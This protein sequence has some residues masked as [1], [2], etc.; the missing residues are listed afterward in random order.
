MTKTLII[1]IIFCLCT[2]GRENLPSSSFNNINK[3]SVSTGTLSALSMFQL[4]WQM[5]VALI[6][7]SCFLILKTPF[8]TAGMTV[9]QKKILFISVCVCVHKAGSHSIHN[10]L[11]PA[12]ELYLKPQ[13]CLIQLVLGII[14][15]DTM[16]ST[17]SALN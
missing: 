17:S 6:T 8:G 15:I 2:Q 12:F 5:F 4:F 7:P 16:H 3:S 9:C 1:I 10:S 13:N 14:S 11:C